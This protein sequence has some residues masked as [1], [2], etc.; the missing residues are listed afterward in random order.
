MKPLVY[1]AGPYT[2]P[3]PVKNTHDAIKLGLDIY[4]TGLAAVEIP[5]LTLLAHIVVPHTDVEY[6]YQFDLEKVL[7][8]QVV[9]RMKGDSSGADKEVAFA[10]ENDIPVFYECENQWQNLITFLTTKNK[11]IN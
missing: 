8:C 9:Y 4:D 6:W 10:L 11:E 7:H 5:H 2:R 3:D 1:V